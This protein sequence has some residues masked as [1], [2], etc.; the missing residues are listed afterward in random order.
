METT[1]PKQKTTPRGEV[2]AMCFICH[3]SSETV[4]ADQECDRYQYHPPKYRRGPLHAIQSP[5][6]SDPIARDFVPGPFNLPRL[7]ETYHST[8][9]PDLLTLTYNHVP[10]GTPK[11]EKADRQ[12]RW[13]G[14]S[15]YFA[16]RPKRSP[17]GHDRLPLVER[18]INFTNI[19]EIKSVAVATYQ[20]LGVK[21]TDYLIAAR[22]AL[23][24]ITGTMPDMT[25]AGG[26]AAA[27][28]VAR[29]RTVG[30]KATLYGNE[31]YEF[32]DRVVHIV[33]PR[34][35]DWPG[36]PREPASPHPVHP[37]PSYFRG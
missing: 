14:D 2:G 32:L 37:L 8:I 5:P 21:N 23:M 35:K 12:R 25:K 10:P 4:R 15:P 33:F 18:D 7:R 20:P 16:N 26:G 9:A 19:P 30:A 22:A 17:R 3:H 27:W 24:A 13:E 36:L 29:G 6:S 31:A 1:G 28:G 34:I 11:V